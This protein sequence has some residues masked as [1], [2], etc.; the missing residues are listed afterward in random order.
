MFMRASRDPGMPLLPDAIRLPSYAQRISGRAVFDERQARAAA[1]ITMVIG[2]VAFCYAYFDK[3]YAPLQTVT[4]FFVV[5]FGLRV[6]LG[7][8]ASPV[9]I[10]AG[11]LT[12]RGAPE[13]VAA[14]PKRF[15]WTLGLVLAA[16]MTAITNSGIRG[17]LPRTICLLCLALMWLEAVLG[18]CIGCKLAGLL[19]R[20][21]WM[22]GDPE[23]AHEGCELH[24]EER[25]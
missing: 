15:A 9:G 25:W 11:A 3:R 12:R 10:V 6:T 17:P 1:G 8:R 20:R 18:L 21:G 16:A 7:L 24:L 23:C 2:A 14:A 13:W 5:E 4:A 19:V 22:H